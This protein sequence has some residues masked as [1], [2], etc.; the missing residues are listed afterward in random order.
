MHNR[1]S[2]QLGCELAAP[3]SPLPDVLPPTRPQPTSPN[4]RRTSA[5]ASASQVTSQAAPAKPAAAAMNAFKDPPNVPPRLN[6]VPAG[7][8]TL[9]PDAAPGPVPAYKAH[10][11]GLKQTAAFGQLEAL[12][13]ERIIMID[14]AMGTMIQRYKLS[15]E[16]FRGQRYASH[17]HELKGNNDLLVVTRPDVIEAIH[18]AYL[19]GGADIIETNTFNGTSIS[20]A[21]YELQAKEEVY[22]IN[23]TAAELAKRCTAAHMAKHPG[24]RK[25]VAGAVGPTNKTLSV[26]PSVENPAFR[27]ITY[28]EVVDA[29]YDQA[30]AVRAPRSRAPWLLGFFGSPRAHT[31]SRPRSRPRPRPRPPARACTRTHA[32]TRSR[33]TRSPLL[34]AR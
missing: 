9:A 13:R 12:M 19:E 30:R 4:A 29:Y 15:E 26:S 28:D 18:T 31:R 23:R 14:G 8:D 3:W 16:D 25:F 33:S 34:R 2:L 1:A 22:H 6:P 10:A 5:G 21:D 11:S 17:G 7:V 24:S 32:R 20:M 27:G